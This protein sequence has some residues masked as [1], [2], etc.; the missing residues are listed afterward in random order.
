[1][2]TTALAFTF[3][4]MI[5]AQEVELAKWEQWFLQQP[6]TLLDLPLDLAKGKDLRSVLFHTLI[7]ELYF[8]ESLNDLRDFNGPREDLFQLPKETVADLFQLHH[9]GLA[10]LKQWVEHT[11][12]ADAAKIF[13]RGE[14]HVSKKKCFIQ[15]MEHTVRHFAQLAVALRQAGHPTDW[16]HDFLFNSSM[17]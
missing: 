3:Q 6:A 14:L 4:E 11:T 15:V 10:L 16:M 12:P 2:S 13:V 5:A 17:I 8:G 7:V 9:R 1:M